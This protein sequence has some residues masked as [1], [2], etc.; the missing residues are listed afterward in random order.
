MSKIEIDFN[1]LKYNLYEILNISSVADDIKIKKSFMKIIK[2]FHPDKNSELEEEIYYHLILANQI[3]LNKESRYKYDLFISDTADT[4]C[5]LKSKF[6]KLDINKLDINTS[7]KS[8]DVMKEKLDINTSTK[9]YDVMKE[10]FKTKCYEL[11][12]KHGY[13]DAVNDSTFDKYSKIKQ[14]RSDIVIDKEDIKTV[15]DFN[16]K[17]D[18]Y[19]KNGKFEMI[20]YKESPQELSTY[21]TGEHYTT[22]GDIDKLYIEDSVQTG[23]FTSLDR[24]FCLYNLEYNDTKTIKDKLDDYKFQTEQLLTKSRVFDTKKSKI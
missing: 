9:S 17:F 13:N 3:L 1:A 6:N 24:A 14:T 5:E 21:V 8:Y 10:S 22:L 12:K 11:N 20:E 4:F 7:T 18:I 19:K 16:S 15:N 2:N 23:K